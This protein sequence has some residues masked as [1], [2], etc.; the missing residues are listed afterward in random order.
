MSHIE[1]RLNELGIK[2]PEVPKPIASYIP[3]K[4]TR[5]LIYTAGQIPV[6]NG[7][8]LKGRLGKDI[9]LDESKN[10]TKHCALVV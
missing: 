6:I 8:N 3:A 4:R 2:L 9:T 1:S 5:N 10:A 7:V